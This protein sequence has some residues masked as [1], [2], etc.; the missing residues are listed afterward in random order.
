MTCFLDFFL[1]DELNTKKRRREWKGKEG[2]E[3]DRERGERERERPAIE[4]FAFL[5]RN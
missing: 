1:D 5:G 4:L 2:E 3:G